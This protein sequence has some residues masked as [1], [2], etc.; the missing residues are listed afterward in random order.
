MEFILSL[1]IGIVLFV[2]L[3]R[4]LFPLILPWLLK[5]LVKR[6]QGRTNFVH[7]FGERGFKQPNPEPPSEP[8]KIVGDDVGEYV[9][10]EEVDKR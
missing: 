9:D 4:L 7:S 1:F 10:F 8:E 2:W 5:G 3:F 6:M